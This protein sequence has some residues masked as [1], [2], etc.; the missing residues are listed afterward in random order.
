MTLIDIPT[1]YMLTG[2]SSL[3]ASL[4]LAWLSR[5]YRD[6]AK[7]LRL[8]GAGILALGGG[9]VCLAVRGHYH[10]TA[11]AMLAYAAFGASAVLN[12]QGC[13]RLFG[14]PARAAE[15]SLALVAYL[16]ALSTLHEASA[17]QAVARLALCSAFMIVFMGLSA[18]HA[19]R[20]QWITVLSS[21]RLMR[22]VM[23]FFCG[24]FA[25]RLLA[26]L[27]DAIPLH[28]DGS[29]PPSTGRLLFALLMGGLPFAL[30]LAA[31]SIANSQLSAEL[32]K[33]ATTDELTG[34]LTRRWLLDSGSR[35][36]ENCS[37][38]GYM[39]LL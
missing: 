25:V 13:A 23:L 30:T 2:I 27:F 29:V 1:V 22:T 37:A 17:Q 6:S 16:V 14:A 4:I 33:T 39:A 8:F 26:Y 19:H 18:L 32:R 38:H 3:L 36:L 15:A 20:S 11:M 9:F 34:L 31:F 35:L 12:W 7:A 5:D 10:D 21:V 28:A 24:V